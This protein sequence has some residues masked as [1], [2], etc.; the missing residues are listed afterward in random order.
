MNGSG[1]VYAGKRDKTEE[2]A[3]FLNKHGIQAEAY[4]AG[5]KAEERP[6]I[7]DRFMRGETR[8]IVATI[9]F[10]MGVDKPD[11]R[12]VIHAHMPSSIENYYQEAGRAGRDGKGA[13]CVLLHSGED[14]ALHKYFIEKNFE[15]SLDRGKPMDEAAEVKRIKY[16]KLDRMLV[17][18]LERSCRRN[19][20]LRYFGDEQAKTQRN[21]NGCDHCLGYEW[22]DEK[23][24]LKFENSDRAISFDEADDEEEDNDMLPM[25]KVVHR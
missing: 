22:E 24:W 13:Y 7:Q 10:G 20:I 4:H 15:E 18:V 21:C 19:M 23:E 3:E 25:T 17:Y 14:Q 11:V 6:L 12:F 16:R 5:L 2:L 9:A 1:I 8:I